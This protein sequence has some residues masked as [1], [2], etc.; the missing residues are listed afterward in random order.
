MP[1]VGE[2]APKFTLPAYPAGPIS[3]DDYAGKKNVILAFYPKDNTPGCTKEMCT[4]SSMRSCFQDL[5]TQVLGISC[6]SLESHQDFASKFDLEQ[7]L[8]SDGEA[9]VGKLYGVLGQGRSMPNRVL[10]VIDK[11]GIVQ[12]VIEG[13]PDNK[14]LLDLLKQLN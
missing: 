6:D 11:L 13:M 1:Q 14:K 5:S 4:F 7:P 3:L 8:L 2:P 10:F 9:V 12:H